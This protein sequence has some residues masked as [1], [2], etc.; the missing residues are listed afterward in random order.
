M[1][2]IASWKAMAAWNQK[3]R[4]PATLEERRVRGVKMVMEQGLSEHEVA[5]ALRVTQGAVSKWMKAYD[6]GGGSYEALKRGKHPG[7]PRMLTEKQ[8]ARIPGM[9]ARGAKHWGFSTD[10][11]TGERVARLIRVKFKVQ[12][13]PMYVTRMLHSFGLSWQKVEKVASEQDQGKLRDWI[14]STLPK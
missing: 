4:D 9:L 13:N 7:K 3:R 5:R 8:L 6:E 11:W 14:L 12:Y 1:G 10:I 2:R